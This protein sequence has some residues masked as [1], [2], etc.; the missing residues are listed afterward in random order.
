VKIHALARLVENV[1][2]VI[3]VNVLTVAV[4]CLENQNVVVP[5]I[6]TVLHLQTHANVKLVD[7]VTV[8]LVVNALH[9]N[10][11]PLVDV[12]LLAIVRLVKTVA[13]VNSMV[14]HVTAS[15]DVIVLRAIA[16]L[17]VVAILVAIV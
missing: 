2:V 8:N 6:V 16:N 12:V 3:I 11:P 5:T 9:V 10:V 17:N 7:P 4:A 1:L 14:A 15:L 13:H